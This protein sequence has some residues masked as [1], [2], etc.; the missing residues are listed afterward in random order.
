MYADIYLC[1]HT[2]NSNRTH[3]VLSGY[4][5]GYS[6]QT[7]SALLAIAGYTWLLG[8]AVGWLPCEPLSALGRVLTSTLLC[9]IEY[10]TEYPME[11]P[12][13][14]PAST[15]L[16]EGNSRGTQGV[17]HAA[18]CTC[19]S[20]SCARRHWPGHSCRRSSPSCSTRTSSRATS[21]VRV[22]ACAC[23]SVSAYVRVRVRA[24]WCPS[25]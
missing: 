3:G 7:A 9:P 24:L 13:E 18:A 12:I 8:T 16:K 6:V 20:S 14:Y 19:T 17:L 10:P 4:S 25:T 15:P 2:Y 23:A 5:T 1:I 22:R 11:F 21:G